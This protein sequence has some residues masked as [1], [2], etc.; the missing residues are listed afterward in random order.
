M[1]LLRNLGMT[2]CDHFYEI[3]RFSKEI[4][5]N[6]KFENLNKST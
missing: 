5:S 1:K 3:D 2:S 4:R 6:F